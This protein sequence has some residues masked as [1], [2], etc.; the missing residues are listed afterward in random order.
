MPAIQQRRSRDADGDRFDDT[1]QEGHLFFIVA[2]RR[3]HCRLRRRRVDDQKPGR[4]ARQ[5]RHHGHPLGTAARRAGS[6]SVITQDDIQLARQQ[7]T[8][9]NRS[10]ACR[11]FLQDHNS[12]SG[13]GSIQLRRL[14]EFR[15][16]RRKIRSTA[17]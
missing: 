11:G 6:V 10:A 5:G 4:C 8:P 2:V 14:R 9:F 17:S 7:L 16:A 13:R 1:V 15:R 12:R 3:L